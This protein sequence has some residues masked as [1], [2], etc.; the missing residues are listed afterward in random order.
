MHA[1]V[2]ARRIEGLSHE[3]EL[4]DNREIVIDEPTADGGTDTGPRPSQL[5][6]GSLAGCTAITI[7]LYAERKG[8]DVEGL[9][10]TADMSSEGEGVPAHAVPT[11]FVVEVAL[12]DGLDDEQRRKLMIIAEKCPVH[13]LLEHG[14]DIT[15]A[16]RPRSS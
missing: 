12:P 16:E 13:R 4:G 11:H 5:L 14:A 15:V 9:E 6:A 8:W 7:E 10:V 3:L 2:T 1:H